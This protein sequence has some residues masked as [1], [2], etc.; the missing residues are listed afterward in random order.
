MI[1]LSREDFKKFVFQRD[2]QK[3]VICGKQGIDVHHLIDRK[4]WPDGGYYL[5]NGVTLC[6]SCHIMAENGTYTVEELRMKAGIHNI[7]LP[8]H[9]D[10]SKIY[11]K[12]GNE[13]VDDICEYD[14]DWYKKFTK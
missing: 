4:C 13:Y 1:L 7:I 9:L 14:K 2:N 10:K 8:P 5:D 3:C 11:D 6:S 12:W